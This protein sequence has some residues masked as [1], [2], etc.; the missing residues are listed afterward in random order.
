MILSM[1]RYDADACARADMNRL[2]RGRD[3]DGVAIGVVIDGDGGDAEPP[4]G[5][6]HADGD[7][8][9]VGDQDLPEHA[10]RLP[11]TFCYP[12]AA[13]GVI[14]FSSSAI[15]RRRSISS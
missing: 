15:A 6:G 1:T 9:A 3:V 5:L 14:D 12:Q 2:V 4:R 8:A 10:R 7:L 11:P 13:R